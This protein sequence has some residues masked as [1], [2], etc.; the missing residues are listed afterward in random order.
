[1]KRSIRPPWRGRRS[2]L[3]VGA[4]FGIAGCA[5][6]CGLLRAGAS[7]PEGACP[8]AWRV[9]EEVEAWPALEEDRAVPPAAARHDVQPVGSAGP[10]V[11]A[12]AVPET[13]EAVAALERA[14]GIEETHRAAAAVSG[15]LWI[16]GAGGAGVEA[17][18]GWI[19]AERGSGDM[20]ALLIRA[21]V[22]GGYGEA[23]GLAE[24]LR[25][26]LRRDP[27]APARAAAAEGAALLRDSRS[28]RALAEAATRDADPSVRRAAT[29]AL[30]CRAPQDALARAALEG[31]A[32]GSTGDP[33][34]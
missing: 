9:G 19:D 24:V 34:R 30:A 18:L 29:H 27:S 32:V 7:A 3:L 31:L 25:A 1:M 8:S 13:I 33:T 16:E 28:A 14:A 20:R 23:D 6:I 11:E 21:L 2:R 17:I 4:A 26:R 15:G 22:A 12:E 10:A 5:A